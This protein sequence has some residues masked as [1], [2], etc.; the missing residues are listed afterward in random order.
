MRIAILAPMKSELASVVKAFSLQRTTIGTTTLHAGSVG[1]V[2]IVAA[3]TG[4]GTA[5][6]QQATERLL[7]ATPVDHV[8]VVGIAG[9]VGDTVKLGDL[10]FPSIVVDKATGNEYRPAHLG[11]PT[12]RGTLV[13]SDDF[14]VEPGV[15]AELAASGVVALDMETSAV[16]EVCTRRRCEWSVTRAISDM[17]TDHPDDAVL[18][19]FKPDGSANVPGLAKFMVTKPWRIPHLVRLGQGSMAAATAAARAAAEA[20]ATPSTP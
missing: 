2:E 6:A 10:V 4:V 20:C 17:A 1:D 5:L 8:M 19:L 18:G 11:N 9:G 13:T 14:H 15:V 12:A 7:D 16:A 3:P